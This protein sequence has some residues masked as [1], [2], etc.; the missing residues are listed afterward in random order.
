MAKRQPCISRLS[1]AKVAVAV[2][3]AA[4]PLLVAHVVVQSSSS[5]VSFVISPSSHHLATRHVTQ[6]HASSSTAVATTDAIGVDELPPMEMRPGSTDAEAFTEGSSVKFWKS[7]FPT[8]TDS[9]QESQLPTISDVSGP[10]SWYW[11][12]HLGRTG[13]FTAQAFTGLATSQLRQRMSDSDSNGGTRTNV[14][15]I[16][17]LMANPAGELR[18]RWEEAMAVYRQDLRNIKQGT[19]KAPYDMSPRHR[20]FSPAYVAGTTRRFLRE[21]SDT[22]AR[23]QAQADTKTWV[24]G[25][26]YPDYYKHTFHYQTDGWFSADSAEVYETSTETLFLG[27]Q[28]AMQ[29]STL[30]HVSRFMDRWQ[31]AGSGTNSKQTPRLLEVAC[32]T[33]RVMTFIRDNWPGLDVTATDLSPF[34]LEKARENNNYW[35]HRFAPPPGQPLGKAQFVQAN[36]EDLPFE[37]SSF[38]AVVS[39]YLFH[40]L[41]SEAQDYVFAEAARVLTPG[42]VFVLTDSMQLGDRPQ[43]DEAIGSFGNFAEPYYKA[44][45]RRDFAAL[46][47]THG[48]EPL[49]KE[50]ISAS[51][52]LSFIK[53][54]DVSETRAV[55]MA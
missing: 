39:V 12:Y 27:R 37:D 51:K 10:D 8:N 33:G 1:T 23:N 25:S 29:R 21:A 31:S 9:F 35:E 2:A 22:L 15:L 34:Y 36:A 7:F 38:D 26:I 30:V 50:L 14:N 5:F 55:D 45:I 6:R 17:A 54:Q 44:Y 18:A 46:A 40:E 28:D 43:Q 53:P 11:L 24:E 32:G 49:D 52:S 41:P 48:L 47:R 4:V 42:G 20:Q 3:T 13:F 19:F 16:D